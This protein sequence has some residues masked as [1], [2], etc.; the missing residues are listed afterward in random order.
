MAERNKKVVWLFYDLDTAIGINNEGALV[1]GY[2]LEDID[3]L[4]SGA[5][6]FNGQKSVLW[7]N[8]RQAF[9]DDIKAM[10]KQLRSSGALSYEKVEKM[11]EDHQ[12]KWPEAVFN[13]DAWFKYLA[14][15]VEKGNATYLSMLQGSKESQR[16]WWLY[17]R[18]KYLDSKYN[19]GDS[20]NDFIELRGYAK[21]DIT[22]TPYA[23]IYASVKYG[24][25]LVQT[26]AERGN[27]YTLVCTLDNVNDTEI[28]VYSASQLESVGDL[29]PLKV[30]RANFSNATKIQSIKLGDAASSYSNGN[31]TELTLGNNSLLRFLDIR[32]CPNLTQPVDVSHCVNLEHLYF[33]G[34]AITGI[35]LPNGGVIKTLHLPSTLANL[36]IRN[37]TRII[38]FS[39]PAYSNI[40]TLRLENVG[41]GVPSM[42]IL[43]GLQDNARVRL[44]GFHWEF[45]DT[46]AVAAFYDKLDRF[47]GL[48]EN[49]GN[50]DQAQVSGSIH[51]PSAKGDALAQLQARYP[52]ITI[53]ADHTE[54]T[55]FYKN[56]D[57][58]ETL[59]TEKVYDGGNGAWDGTPARGEDDHGIY[60]FIG[61]SKKTDATAAD[62]SALTGISADRSVY[63]AYSV[64]RKNYVRYYSDDGATLLHTE[65]IVGTGDAAYD[66]SPSKES[67]VQ[68]DYAFAG[69]ST[70]KGGSVD[71]EAQKDVSSDRNLYAAYTQ[72]VRS[73]DIVFARKSTDG[74][75][76]LQTKT[77]AYGSLPEYTGDT[78]VYAGEGNP[79]MFEFIGWTPAV[80]ACTG[81]QTYYAL[82]RDNTSDVVRYGLGALQ[83]YEGGTEAIGSYALAN[84]T[85]LKSAKTSATDIGAYAFSGDTALEYVDLASEEPVTIHENAFSGTTAM[86][87]MIIRSS[88][89]A[90]VDTDG[91]KDCGARSG[92]FYVPGELV[93]SYKADDSW[94]NCFILPIGMYPSMETITDTWAQIKEAE[95]DGTYTEKYAIGDT[96]MVEIGGKQILMEIVGFDKDVAEDGSTVPITWMTKYLNWIKPYCSNNIR[97]QS[98]AKSDLKPYIATLYSS[99]QED[100]AAMVV[101]VKKCSQSYSSSVKGPVYDDSVEVCWAPSLREIGITS[102]VEPRGPV[103]E[104]FVSD[105]DRIRFYQGAAKVYYCRTAAASG[106]CQTVSVSG[107][108]VSG[109]GSPYAYGFLLGFCT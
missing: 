74:G 9:Y 20:L 55:L 3:H 5:D 62:A 40:S 34:T 63:A 79:A 93:D 105:S 86:E 76:T 13:E 6:I 48:D 75:G 42:E 60:E 106:Y 18:F 85:S 58:S 4:P 38:D 10:Y 61:W 47:R 29:A 102:Q 11:F 59:H 54:A 91:L 44:V 90:S 66:G 95:E 28:A 56:H 49:G 82:F 35:S 33:D 27:Q 94:K 23:D 41:E 83:A 25:Y 51:L 31:L 12:D 17:N 65:V 73:Y 21:G 99:M 69:W 84:Q 22:V 100:V 87:R 97:E 15:L 30:G 16:K 98:Y 39:M 8:L 64:T 70:A 78:P 36:T 101:P 43:D 19:A 26:R 108:T 67:T 53:T 72:T 109:T 68:Y 77:V 92:A 52:Y 96:K 103:Y 46:D 24:S 37:Q 7:T 107:G 104:Q 45:D 89:V 1:F 2:N 81:A 14:P 88:E 57:G 50:M 80:T 71:A 32:N